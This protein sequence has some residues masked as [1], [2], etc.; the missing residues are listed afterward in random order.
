MIFIALFALKFHDFL[1]V[2]P[3]L[4]DVLK[5]SGHYIP[6]IFPTLILVFP[7]SN[8]KTRTWMQVI[9]LGSGQRKHR[10][11]NEKIEKGKDKLGKEKCH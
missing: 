3:G 1:I 2:L 11:G 5:L 7:Q 9:Y 10:R 4:I 6:K 8:S